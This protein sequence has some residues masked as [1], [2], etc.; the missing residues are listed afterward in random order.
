MQEKTNKEKHVILF[1]L[2]SKNL[3]FVSSSNFHELNNK[4]SLS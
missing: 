1:N 2:A 4:G 3:S